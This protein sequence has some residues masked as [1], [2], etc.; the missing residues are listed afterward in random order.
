MNRQRNGE[1]SSKPT[2][3]IS[4]TMAGEKAS[5]TV[6]VHFSPS[7]EEQLLSDH[8][9]HLFGRT[10]T[11]TGKEEFLAIV[12][13]VVAVAPPAVQQLRRRRGV[14]LVGGPGSDQPVYEAHPKSTRPDTRHPVISP[15]GFCF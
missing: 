3:R 10:I 1:T 12:V 14:R 5:N 13:L 2:L 9:F 6:V 4:L 11:I 7:R 15:A 8:V